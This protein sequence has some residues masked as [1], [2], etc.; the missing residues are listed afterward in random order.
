MS[1]LSVREDVGVESL[2]GRV[3]DEF[4]ERLNRGESPDVEEYA[5]RYPQIADLLR[6]ALP[7]LQA[8]GLSSATGPALCQP[9][10]TGYLGDYRILR[11]VGRGGMGVV[12]EAEQVSLGRRVA[13]KVLPFAAA[14]DARQLQRFKNEAQAAA[15]LHHPH[16]VPVYAVGCER[17]VH[18]YAMQFID[19]QALDAVLADLRRLAGLEAEGPCAAAGAEGAL[20]TQQAALGTQP[21]TRDASYFRTVARLGAQVAQALEHAHQ[22]GIVHRDIKPANLLVDGRGDVW[23]TDFGLAQFWSDARL[24]RT[25]DVLGTLRYM[26][27]EQALANRVPV[28]HRTDLYSL[29]ATLYELLTLQPTFPGRSRE[30]LLAQIALEEPQPP[31]RVNRA[32]PAD[33]ETVVLKALAKAPE[34][35]YATAQELADDLERFLKDL[36]IRAKRPALAQRAAKWARRHRAVVGAAAVVLAVAVVALAVSTVVVWRKQVQARRAYEAEVQARAAEA[37]QRRRA[38]INAHL[39]LA[40]EK[41]YLQVMEPRSPKD[42]QAEQEDRELFRLVLTS[43]EQSAQDNTTNPA[44]R[45]QIGKAYQHIG[46]IYH[47]LGHPAQAEQALGRAIALWEKLA[48]DSPAIPEHRRELATCRARLGAL[49][50]QADRPREAEAHLRQALAAQKK[51]ADDAPAEPVYRQDLARTYDNLG[52]LLRKLGRFQQAEEAHRE[53]ERLCDRLV[54]EKEPSKGPRSR[55]ELACVSASLG[56]LLLET[57][58]LREAEQAYR[59]ALDLQRGLVKELP[60]MTA[61]REQLAG[62][63]LSL[64]VVLERA[65]DFEKASEAYG[66]ARDLWEKLAGDF[67]AFPEYRRNLA[68]SLGNLGVARMRSGRAREAEAAWCRAL[69]LQDKLVADFPAV[70]AYRQDLAGALRNLGTLWCNLGRA[71]DA[72]PLFRRAVK[73]LDQPAAAPA[74]RAARAKLVQALNNLGGLLVSTSRLAEAEQAYRRAIPLAVKLTADFPAVLDYRH[75]LALSHRHLGRV[76]RDTGRPGEAEQAFARAQALLEKLAADFPGP[77]RFRESLA[78]AHNDRGALWDVAE[79]RKA[80]QAYREALALWKKLADDMPQA[81][82]IRGGLARTYHNLGMALQRTGQPVEASAAY[83][84][85]LALLDKLPADASALPAS[86]ECRALLHNSRGAL[87]QDAGLYRKAEEAYRQALALL[88]PLAADF[89]GK[90][91]YPRKLATT[92]LNLGAALQRGG[93]P[94]EAE[95]SYRLSL[96]ADPASP[97]AHDALASL[98][99][100]CPDPQVRNPA[101]A[102]PLAKK[103]VE[104]APQVGA[105]WHTLGMAHLTVG[106]WKASIE[107]LE[108][109]M[110]LRQGGDCTDWFPLA[111]AYGR[112]GDKRKALQYYRRGV[113]WMEE[114]E[115]APAWLHRARGNVEALLGLPKSP[116][117]NGKEGPPE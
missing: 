13:L 42:P 97:A 67:P 9:P 23:V 33:L 110:S 112:Q 30:E 3:A 95:N 88:G 63:H 22:Q 105:Y 11:E 89:P 6:Q 106:D 92:H 71:P 113:R 65:G 60:R 93:R 70:S 74:D 82:D 79:P 77:P 104:L 51:L 29:G 53:A 96:K 58:R 101:R 40:V 19:G 20:S 84:A 85:G 15:H 44:A 86:R 57:G 18:Y 26:S 48:A 21:S 90:A 39:A 59:R 66:Q 78:E 16:I 28:D 64:G 52:V 10:L 54:K 55:H 38:E 43:Y 117:P 80:E 81:A 98:L 116:A 37:E 100:S 5:Q 87:F 24:T 12:Y 107:A 56:A 36:P 7:A 61:C 50:G 49:L 83:R 35:R 14:L 115:P 69:S 41:I 76:L 1:D 103:A 2:V 34:E 27:P 4:T 72:E 75:D 25:G 17:G 114:N 111:A 47:K 31:G 45:L 73:L 68:A 91:D 94:R 46:L 62:A 99:T 108:K 109:S 102:V 8:L 32:V